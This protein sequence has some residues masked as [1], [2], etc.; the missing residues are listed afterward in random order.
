MDLSSHYS[1]GFKILAQL[2]ITGHRPNN[3]QLKARYENQCF[4]AKRQN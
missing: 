2:I 1:D 3:S 4:G